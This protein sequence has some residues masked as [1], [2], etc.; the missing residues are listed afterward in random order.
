MPALRVTVIF[1]RELLDYADKLAAQAGLSRSALV[2][3]CIETY[4]RIVRDKPRKS[5]GGPSKG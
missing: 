2:K 5:R 4:G 1:D 3:A